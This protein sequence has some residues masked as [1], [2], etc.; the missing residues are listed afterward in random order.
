MS[1]ALNLMTA[2]LYLQIE[3][4]RDRMCRRNEEFGVESVADG[5]RFID[6]VGVVNALTDSL[7][8]RTPQSPATPHLTDLRALGGHQTHS[9]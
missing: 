8:W 6:D 2:T 4:H 5:E 7:R 9:H 3:L 1:A